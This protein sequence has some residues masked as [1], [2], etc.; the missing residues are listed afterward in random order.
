MEAEREHT[1]APNELSMED[2]GALFAEIAATAMS[3]SEGI[4]GCVLENGCDLKIEVAL[5]FASMVK[6]MGWVAD[7]GVAQIRGQRDT[8][9]SGDAATWLCGGDV[10]AVMARV[11]RRQAGAAG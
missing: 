6:R 10:G 5:A 4:E 11:G 9:S 2:C 8:V 1:A 3:V 7:Y